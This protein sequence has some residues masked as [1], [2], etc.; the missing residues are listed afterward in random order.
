MSRLFVFILFFTLIVPVAAHPT[1]SMLVING[2]LL[3]SYVCPLDDTEH[4]A[5]VMR[6]DE[7]NGVRPWLT[8]TFTASDWMMA[9]APNNQVFLAERHFDQIQQINKVRLLVASVGVTP[10]EL[11]SWFDDVHRFG[12]GGFAVLEDG[13]F[14]F[15]RYPKLY[16]LN[17]DGTTTVWREWPA[18]VYGLRQTQDGSLLI[19]G[20]AQ[21]WLT[22]HDG[23]LLKSWSGLLQQLTQEPPFMGNRI[24]DADYCADSLGIAYWGKRRF[25]VI[26]TT[27]RTVLMSFNQPW[28]PHAVACDGNIT[29]MLAST[30]EPGHERGIRPNLWRLKDGVLDR[31]WGEADLTDR[32]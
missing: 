20:E 32:K 21:A 8:S 2:T 3:W 18:P 13:R 27:S 16:I 23:T 29:Y 12:E 14:L 19:R 7:E 25:D 28:L 6:F 10:R 31:L 9:P 17:K 26:K 4:H 1:G 15:A 24:F 5:C 11:I 22:A 30:L